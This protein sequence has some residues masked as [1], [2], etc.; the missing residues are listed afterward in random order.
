MHRESIE[1]VNKFDVEFS[2]ERS[3]LKYPEHESGLKKF[4]SA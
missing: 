3:V 1:I 4:L 2:E